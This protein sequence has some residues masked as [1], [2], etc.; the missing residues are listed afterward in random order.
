MGSLSSKTFLTVLCIFK[1]AH[2]KVFF[3]TASLWTLLHVSN[4]CDIA[5]Q[6]GLH[7]VLQL[8]SAFY[9]EVVLKLCCEAV[10]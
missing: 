10:C 5:N 1:I 4:V 7:D 6:P 3:V 2:K 9:V 8:S